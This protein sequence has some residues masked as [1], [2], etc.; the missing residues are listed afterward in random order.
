MSI[1]SIEKLLSI[2]TP[3]TSVAEVGKT[4]SLAEHRGELPD[5][6]IQ[7]LSKKN[8][9][10]AFEEALHVFS[11][12]DSISQG[13]ILGLQAWNEKTLWRD[14]YQGLTEE[15]FFF[16]E[17]I[18]GG[19][20]ALKGR[21]VVSFDPESGEIEFLAKSIEDWAAE[22]LLNYPQLTGYPLA[23]SWQMLNGPIARGKRLLPKIPFI[24][25]GKYEVNN[26]F[27]VD[28]VKGMRYR[29]ELWEQL[30]D[31]PDGAKVRL[32]ALPLQ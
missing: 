2:S 10:Y 19:Q 15:L 26:L 18:F 31:L 17:D 6:L 7:I 14:W 16:A 1:I 29:G 24:L 12:D 22:I 8:G 30:R 32:K 5:E 21:E 4:A 13:Q 28:A 23:H 9:F 3:A 20:F 27:A 11:W 25:G